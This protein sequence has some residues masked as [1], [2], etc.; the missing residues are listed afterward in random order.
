MSIAKDQVVTIHYTVQNGDGQ[1]I[2]SS[3]GREPL[4]YL[5]GH[6]NIIPGLEAALEGHDEGESLQVSIEPEQAYGRREEEKIV[7]VSRED[8]PDDFDVPEGEM[9]QSQNPDGS[10]SIFTVQE[11]REQEVVL[12]GNHPLADQTLHFDVEVVEVREATGEEI[13]HGHAHGEHGHEH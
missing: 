7:A 9:V 2:D 13:E 3:D 1:T 12:D 6:E 11:N 5:H 8:L 4:A 10:V